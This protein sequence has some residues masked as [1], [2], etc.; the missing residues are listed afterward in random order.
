MTETDTS[1]QH[2]NSVFSYVDVCTSIFCCT[3]H[4][5]GTVDV[6]ITQLQAR[7]VL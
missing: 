2:V 3:V 6:D 5:V 4:S 7:F 1:A